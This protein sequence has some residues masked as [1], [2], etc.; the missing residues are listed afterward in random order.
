MIRVLPGQTAVNAKIY[1]I[2]DNNEKIED[3]NK[4]VCNIIVQEFIETENKAK[5]I[6]IQEIL[7]S[8]TLMILHEA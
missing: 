3:Q 6:K 4:Q 2:G 5:Y 8:Q 1:G 7:T